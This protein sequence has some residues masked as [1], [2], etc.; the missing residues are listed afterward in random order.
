MPETFAQLQT[1]LMLAANAP[2]PVWI[3]ALCDRCKIAWREEYAT[4]LEDRP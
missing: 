2:Y 4:P 1:R 3:K